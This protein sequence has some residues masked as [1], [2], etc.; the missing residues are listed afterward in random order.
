[1]P[2][3]NNIYNSDDL[4]LNASRKAITEFSSS[5]SEKTTLKVIIDENGIKK[6][7]CVNGIQKSEAITNV[8][9][10]VKFLFKFDFNLILDTKDFNHEKIIKFIS[11]DDSQE[12]LF[13]SEIKLAVI[14]TVYNKALELALKN[15]NKEKLF[16]LFDRKFEIPR[17][18][19]ANTRL[20]LKNFP[21]LLEMLT[22]EELTRIGNIAI[23]NKNMN[24][25][26]DTIILS[27]NF[28]DFDQK[29]LLKNAYLVFN[30]AGS[31][32]L[33]SICP[34]HLKYF[35]LELNSSQHPNDHPLHQ[36]ILNKDVEKLGSILKS[37][38][39]SPYVFAPDADGNTPLMLA[40]KNEA[41]D[42]V[43]EL[44]SE[45]NYN[46]NP[47]QFVSS[48]EIYNNLSNNPLELEAYRNFITKFIMKNHFITNAT[49]VAPLHLL[50]HVNN[51][52]II[53]FVLSKYQPDQFYD[54][55]V[56]KNSEGQ[57]F[58]N[59]LIEKNNPSIEDLQMKFL[60]E[61]YWLSD[62]KKT[63]ILSLINDKNL[64][65]KLII[66]RKTFLTL[67]LF[68]V[69]ENPQ[70]I[71]LAFSYNKMNLVNEIFYSNEGNTDIKN[72]IFDLVDLYFEQT[73]KSMGINFKHA[74]FESRGYENLLNLFIKS[75]NT[76]DIF[77][78]GNVLHDCFLN[79]DLSQ[80]LQPRLHDIVKNKNLRNHLLETTK[81]FSHCFQGWRLKSIVRLALDND[82]PELIKWVKSNYSAYNLSPFMPELLKS[83]SFC[84]VLKDYP[85]DIE[86]YIREEGGVL[87]LPFDSRLSLIA[88][89]PPNLIRKTINEISIMQGKELLEASF[90]VSEADILNSRG[91]VIDNDYSRDLLLVEALEYL[92]LNRLYRIPQDTELGAPLMVAQLKENLGRFSLTALAYMSS[93]P[94]H[95]NTVFQFIKMFEDHHLAV[96]IPQLSP[97][98]FIKLARRLDDIEWH[99]RLLPFTT[100]DQRFAYLN[101]E[102]FHEYYYRDW[103]EQ[104]VKFKKR[105]AEVERMPIGLE[106]NQKTLSL[107]KDFESYTFNVSRLEPFSAQ[108]E[109]LADSLKVNTNSVE[110]LLRVNKQTELVLEKIG[111]YKQKKIGQ[112]KKDFEGLKNIFDLK[113]FDENE[114]EENFKDPLTDKIMR[115]PLIVPD[116]GI[117]LDESTLK[118][119]LNNEPGHY[120]NPYNRIQYPIEDY[121]IDIELQDKVKAWL[122]LKDKKKKEEENFPTVK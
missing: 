63:Q 94:E 91:E 15:K 36:A 116:T 92:K 89:L 21:D 4:N 86:K 53:K 17:C 96:I 37:P 44:L 49:G 74:Y 41:E 59:E 39:P 43:L 10:V 1:M 6:L 101:H 79:K 26:C 40:I 51:T 18:N 103:T 29:S 8:K 80:K 97:K 48:E 108:L 12:P 106:R 77:I 75:T 88:F 16:D 67:E 72:K 61:L 115:T 20:N 76:D 22:S 105:L 30:E 113:V 52:S 57:A 54:A 23:K 34:P 71:D 107:Q 28:V 120:F 87:T 90:N 111:S 27:K 33:Y 42:M 66:E 14:D 62:E 46:I 58:V 56:I 35:L 3:I 104:S 70:I 119:Q 73:I 32:P 98:N 110:G 100:D 112:I 55:L 93:R 65:I 121:R 114:P 68:N 19:T 45:R 25:V 85:E 5:N 2:N 81:F 118:K 11:S 122:A 64:F 95:Q 99:S 7:V 24:L 50:L 38:S 31:A 13:M 117:V 78:V 47:F 9:E 84:K 69:L 60:S 83:A 102:P 109:K 82:F